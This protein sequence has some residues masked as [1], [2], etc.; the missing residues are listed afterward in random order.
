MQSKKNFKFEK[1]E[2][3]VVDKQDVP[4]K[5]KVEV[6][7]LCFLSKETQTIILCLDAG[8]L[9]AKLRTF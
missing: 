3:E 9:K 7:K 5:K 2:F 4:F 8:S 1:G 6:V